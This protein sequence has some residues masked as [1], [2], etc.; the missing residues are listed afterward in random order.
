M[1]LFESLNLLIQK[2]LPEEQIKRLKQAYLVA[3]DAHEGQTRS[4]GEPYITHPVAVACIL[5]EMRLDYETLMAALLHDVIED[6]PATYQDMEQLFGKSVAELV[7]GVSKLDKLKFRDKKEAQA[8]N[9]RKMIMAMV[10]DIRVIL[11]KLADRTHNMRTLGSLRPDKRRRIARETLEIYSPLAH[12][13][14]I[15][16]L[17]T[18]LEELGFEALYPNRYRV[19]KEVVKAARGNRKEMIQ[20]ILSE[21]EGRLTEA[22]IEC[23]VN[24][25]EK[26]LYSIYRKMH[27]KEQRFHSIMDIYAFRVIVKDVDTCYRVLGQAH[28]LY[29][30][31]PG[32]VKDYIAIPK[33]NGYQ[34]LHTSLIGPH[35]VPVEVQIRTEDMDQMAEMGVAAH[36]AYKEGESSTTAQIRAQRWMQ[37]LLELQQ[38]AGSSFEFIE[39]VK[40]DLFPDEIY[41]FTPEGRIVELPAGATPVDFAYAVHTDIGHACV[42]ARVDRQPYP[43]SQALHSG[44]NVEIITAPGARPNAAWLNFVVSSKARAKIRQMLKNLKRDDSVSLGRRLLNHALGNGRKLSDLPPENIQRELDRMK[45]HSMDDLLAEV[46][47][48]NAMS[49]VVA[50]NLLGDPQQSSSSSGRKL[51][52]KGAD[53]VLLTFA[54]CCRPIPGDP[55]IAHVSPGKGLVIHH[56]SCRNIRGYQKEPEKFMA[57]EWDKDIEQEFIAEIKVD[58]FNHQG[59]LANLTAA[60]NATASNIQSMNTEEKDGRVYSAFIR[61]TTRDRVHLANIMRKI[62]IMPDVIKVNRNRN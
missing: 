42:G 19:I 34:S 28:S 58:M 51:P 23:H 56:E 36:W 35:G 38:S 37:S 1:Y 48:G 20:K 4:S 45:L 12:R 59:A 33:A 15:H 17:K 14:G 13:L 26:H 7:E 3:R 32:R 31:R 5:A 46:G 22:G 9:F 53:G 27:L 44:Q 54:K 57:V 55:I 16:H 49:V 18:E 40:S 39:S 50:K 29:K 11:I 52:I 43:L 25:R 10:Q 2:Y 60:I 61:L 41:V 8:E 62:R 6:T 24:G 30:P 47:L 21:I